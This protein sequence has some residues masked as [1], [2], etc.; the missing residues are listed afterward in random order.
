[1]KHHNGPHPYRCILEGRLPRCNPD[2]LL[3]LSVMVI[4]CTLAGVA[5]VRAQNPPTEY[6]VKAAYLYQFGK[7]VE[8]PGEAVVL[9]G[10]T[11]SI[12]TLGGNPFGALLE[13]TI[14]GRSVQ[15]KKVV[16]KAMANANEALNCNILF[17][18]SSEQKRLEEIFR[19]LHGRSILTVG[20]M[21]NFLPQG[22]M[23]Q[24]EIEQNKVRFEINV[25]A[26]GR[27]NLKISS[28]LLKVAKV[29][30]DPFPD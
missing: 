11:F 8:W 19:I 30:N 1:M 2:L 23:I 18:I 15:G 10:D 12:C 14:S 16:A 20:D 5:I 27:A 3:R 28:Q 13:E 17:I 21:K 6:E 22:G 25:S 26:V 24:L 9:P 4:L 7:F 29:T